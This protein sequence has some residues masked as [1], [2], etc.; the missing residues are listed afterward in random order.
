MAKTIYLL[1]HGETEFNRKRL[2]QG[3]GVDSDLN[4]TGTQQA[5]A[6]FQKYGHLPFE[7]VYTSAL[8]RTQQTMQPFVHRGISWQVFPELN[9]M[10]WGEHEGKQ[11]TPEMITE[12]QTVKNQWSEGQYHA[13]VRGGESAA[14]LAARL[15]RF[16]RH[17]HGLSNELVLICSHG[18]AMCGLVSLLKGDPLHTMNSYTHSN[19]GLW[20][21]HR[22]DHYYE[23]ALENDTSHLPPV[24]QLLP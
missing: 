22:R 12:Y 2:I 20:I 11:S 8:R 7:A 13:R 15:D 16:I 17:L 3:S 21:A 18:R 6:F 19:T 4:D 5:T 23:F 1:R 14:E 24:E 10:S 9:E